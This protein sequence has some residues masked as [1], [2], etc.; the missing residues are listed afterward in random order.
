MAPEVSEAPFRDDGKLTYPYTK[1]VDIW[2]MG[3]ILD[4]L[5]RGSQTNRSQYRGPATE[6]INKMMMKD[7]SKRP[8]A[9]ECLQFPWLR[10]QEDC[11]D[12]G[13]Q[14]RKRRASSSP[15]NDRAKVK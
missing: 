11:S 4:E 15:T 12:R 6:L 13:P 7:P 5:I 3:K 8:T 2:A 9:A 10:Q 14:K 1:A